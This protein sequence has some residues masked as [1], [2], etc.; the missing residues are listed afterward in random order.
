MIVNKI[1]EAVIYEAEDGTEKIYM[2][3]QGGTHRELHRDGAT[4]KS[5]REKLKEDELWVDIRQAAETNP[6]I[7]QVLDEA[8]LLYRL[9]K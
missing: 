4:A 8:I 1:T 9:S 3:R 7:K 5:L 6:T 2:K